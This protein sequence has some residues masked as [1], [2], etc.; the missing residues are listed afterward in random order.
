MILLELSVLEE[1]NKV[2]LTK[3]NRDERI[4]KEFLLKIDH[5]IP[6]QIKDILY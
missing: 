4:M 5:K 6:L 2:D 3:L 1:F